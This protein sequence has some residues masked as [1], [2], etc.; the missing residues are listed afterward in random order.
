MY[1]YKYP[2]PGYTADALIF[3]RNDARNLTLILIR[4]GNEPFLGSWALPGGFVNEG[5]TSAD[6]AR[7][8]LQEETGLALDQTT[9]VSLV[10]IYD[11]PGRDPRGWT[12]SAAYMTFLPGEP[13]A[14]GADDAAEAQ[15]HKIAALPPLA[16][17]HENI[18]IDAL[19]KYYA[20]RKKCK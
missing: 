12:I 11:A 10:G 9:D 6:A 17:D 20:Q 14:Q 19:E 8:E 1:E 18:I 5:E 15:W 4:R 2:R 13:R 7:R 3:S 16:F